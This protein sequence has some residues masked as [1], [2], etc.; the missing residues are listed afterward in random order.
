MRIVVRGG[1]RKQKEIARK[2]VGVSCYSLLSNKMFS[3][4][5]CNIKISKP[6]GLFGSCTW[7][8]TNLRPREFTIEIHKECS[9]KDFITTLC[10]ESVH[11]KQYAKGELRELYKGGHR[12][13]WYDKD[14]M[15]VPYMELPWE[16]E[17]NALEK[18]LYRNFI[19]FG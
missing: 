7:E 10:H 12:L 9:E 2:V 16:L 1:N 5:R 6:S 18:S 19:R 11:L 17:A 4:I 14:C 15:G 8:D 13:M 3:N